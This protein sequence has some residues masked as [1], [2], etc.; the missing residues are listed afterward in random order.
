MSAEVI[1]SYLVSLSAQ[2]DMASFTKM[3][4]VL[5]QT[6]A[7]VKKSVGGIVGD[8]LSFQVAATSAF[9]AASFGIIGYIDHLAM[10]DQKTRMLA[11]QNMMSVQQYR[12]VSVA[13]KTMGVSLDDV[14]FG[15][16]QMQDQFH[17][18]IDDQKQLAAMLGPDY[19]KQMADVR[20]VHFQLERLQVKGE[21]FGM[22]FASDLLRKL[23]FGEDGIG[24]QLE[25]LNVWV[26]EKMP[27]W[28][29]ELSSDVIPVLRDFWGMVKDI[30]QILGVAANA[31]TN[32]EGAVTGDAG[33]QGKTTD[34]HQFAS[35]VGD[36][37][38][39]LAQLLL[40]T[41]D[42]EKA[43]VGLGKFTYHG[44]KSL[45]VGGDQK[46]IDALTNAQTNDLHSIWSALGDAWTDTKGMRSPSAGTSTT[47]GTPSQALSGFLDS[48][49]QASSAL[50]DAIIHAESRGNPNAVSNRGAIGLMQLMPSVAAGMG[51]DPRDP[52]QNRAGGTRLIN[53]L[54]KH[55]GGNVDAS[56][57]AYNWGEGNVDSYLKT[58]HGLRTASN[59]NGVYPE[60]TRK[61]VQGITGHAPQLN[62][63][64]H[65]GTVNSS[66]PEQIADAAKRGAG[67]AYREY[68]NRSMTELNGAYQ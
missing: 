67:E 59:P 62:V 19:E 23:G 18:L 51:V 15:T 46:K 66:S 37:V 49:G 26:M 29:D 9:G 38:H 61:Y 64:V 33:L 17:T 44:I 25:R 24:K 42:L 48:Q 20:D 12:A 43:G 34:F 65:V 47:A 32:F 58:G 10:A 41:L 7:T 8:L 6:E 14:F 2:S 45:F 50:I 56:L 1:K 39:Q 53:Q 60:E 35:A 55:Y 63:Q 4:G 28:S 21:Y 16:K 3:D 36:A 13:L 52:T 57:S 40:I 5:K 31:F 27:A 30:G 68:I 22:K 11:T 54:L